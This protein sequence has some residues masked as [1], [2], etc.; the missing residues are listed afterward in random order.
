MQVFNAFFKIVNKNKGSIIMYFAVFFGLSTMISVATPNPASNAYAQVKVPVAVINRDNSEIA[1]SIVSYIKD[2]QKYVELADNKDDMQD[3]L[4]FR[5]VEFILIIPEN[6]GTRYEN[7]ERELLESISIPDSYSSVFI[8][9]QVEQYLSYMIMYRDTS[10]T[11]EQAQKKAIEIMALEVPVDYRST[12]GEAAAANKFMYY[13]QYM[14]YMFFAIMAQIIGLI[15]LS[16]NAEEVRKRMLCSSLTLKNKN[17]QLFAGCVALALV[18]YVIVI[19]AGLTVYGRQIAAVNVLPYLMINSFTTLI[20]SVSAGF[21]A[22]SFVKNQNQ[23][24]AVT[25]IF[26]LGFSFLGGVFVTLD[27]LGE[28]VL[29]V[30]KFTPTYW[31][32]VNNTKLGFVGPDTVINNGEFF[33]GIGIQMGFALLFISATLVIIKKKSG[34]A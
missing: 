23:L 25:N 15:F 9:M 11:A 16:F 1:S 3:A 2:T 18:V 4:F 31:Y 32:V 30:S 5:A 21:F 17:L 10:M 29:R 33:G 34:K 19:G 22:G 7:G 27:L 6:F 13:F 8:N 14:P 26:S 24:A 28:K 20:V 12:N